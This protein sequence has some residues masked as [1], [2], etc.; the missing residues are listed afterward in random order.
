MNVYAVT[1]RYNAVPRDDLANLL[2]FSGNL[3]T[4]DGR[5][6]EIKPSDMSLSFSN[7]TRDMQLYKATS[8]CSQPQFCWALRRVV[9]IRSVL[10]VSR[11]LYASAQI[12][13]L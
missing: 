6:K 11:L 3:K 8:T 5:G 9:G 4:M 10:S 7:V 13:W 2:L 12:Y 1:N